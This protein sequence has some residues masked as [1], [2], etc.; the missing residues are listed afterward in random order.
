MD[1]PDN[2]ELIYAPITGFLLYLAMGWRPMFVIEPLP[3]GHGRYS[4]YLWRP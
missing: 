2:C 3:G 1:V 4:L